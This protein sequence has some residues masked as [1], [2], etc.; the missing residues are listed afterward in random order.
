MT[1]HLQ[2]LFFSAL[3]QCGYGFGRPAVAG[4][5]HTPQIFAVIGARDKRQD[6]CFGAF[7]P[8]WDIRVVVSTRLLLGAELTQ[9]R[10]Y[11]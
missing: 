1:L 7:R 9:A 8:I 6:A 11:P 5:D 2:R 10:R 3:N 4:A